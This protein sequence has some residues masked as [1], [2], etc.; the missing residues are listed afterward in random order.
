MDSTETWTWS[1]PIIRNWIVLRPKGCFNRFTFRLIRKL[2]WIRLVLGL[3]VSLQ[4][5]ILR[6]SNIGWLNLI[7][8]EKNKQ[9]ICL[10]VELLNCTSVM[11][12]HPVCSLE[13][14]NFSSNQVSEDSNSLVVVELL[15]NLLISKKNCE[16][17]L[18]KNS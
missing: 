8:T 15:E 13:I 12:C 5:A 14:R 11:T 10:T 7:L 3:N 18:S 17:R 6:R 16:L 4:F 9:L 2:Y 1:S